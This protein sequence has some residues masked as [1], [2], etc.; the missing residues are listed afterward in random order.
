MPVAAAIAAGQGHPD[1]TGGAQRAAEIPIEA[2]PAV[3]ARHDIALRLVRRQPRAQLGAQRGRVAGWIEGK[4]R[5]ALHV[6]TA[7]Q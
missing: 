4:E 3:G 6:P 5:K 7:M 1:V 2:R